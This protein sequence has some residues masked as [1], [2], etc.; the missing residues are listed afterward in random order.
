[1]LQEIIYVADSAMVTKQNLQI[2]K[3][4]NL[5]FI[6]RLPG[7]FALSTKTAS[8]LAKLCSTTE[9]TIYRDIKKL[10]N[11]GIQVMS[12]GKNGYC[13]VDTAQVNIPAKLNQEEY[14]A[15]QLFH[16]MA[17][18]NKDEQSILYKS[19]N[20]AM[21]KVMASLKVDTS[22]IDLIKS[23][24]ERIRLY[25]NQLNK[26]QLDFTKILVEALINNITVY[27]TYDSASSG[28]IH[29][30]NLDPYYLITRA[31]N[32]YLIAYCHHHKEIRT[33]RLSRFKKIVLTAKNFSLPRN[34]DIDDYLSD[35]WQI[36]DE[37]E[38]ITFR[39]RFA[40]TIARY[41]REEIYYAN[42]TI[43]DL[44][45]GDLLLEVTVKSGS[46]FLRWLMKYGTEAEILSPKKYRQK[47][48]QE[49]EAMLA[50]Y[51]GGEDGD[52]Q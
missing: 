24:N 43:T 17:C 11:L 48:K 9:R 52:N 41:V 46:E 14:L 26:D 51:T 2:I 34:F 29:E 38:S 22:Q 1:N 16:A 44:P 39:V 5:S 50:L 19:Y 25:D 35:M 6:S 4:K 31:G 36:F 12:R 20:S 18:Q 47:M 7:T 23:L 49:I 45:D 13:L 21:N 37:D 10:D 33:Y 8:R 32:Y 42:P 27:C 15:L 40:K 28:R 30:R 3:E